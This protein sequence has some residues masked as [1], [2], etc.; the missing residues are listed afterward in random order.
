MTPAQSFPS[1]PIFCTAGNKVSIDSTTLS[2]GYQPQ[3]QLPC[4]YY[5]QL[6]NTETTML[7]TL[8]SGL[9]NITAELDLVVASGGGTPSL[10]QTN[11]V[12]A[13]LNVLYQAQAAAGWSTALGNILGSNWSTALNRP[14]PNSFNVFQGQKVTLTN[15]SGYYTVPSGVY[16]LRVTCVGGG[17]GGTSGTAGVA[18]GNGGPTTFG[19]IVASGSYGAPVGNA[20]GG[21]GAP[22]GAGQ[23][24]S[25][26]CGGGTIISLVNASIIS[27][28]P[29]ALIT[30]SV[31]VGGTGGAQGGSQGTYGGTGGGAGAVPFAGTPLTPGYGGGGAY[32]LSTYSGGTGGSGIIII[33]Y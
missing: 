27:T 18:G 11:Q 2:I 7:N 25:Q 17:G 31:G 5:N 8:V 14:L 29:G 24:G 19:A 22:G 16:Q 15:G 12:M 3:Q 30:Y 28:T 26:G 21:G 4:E 1:L 10:A 6:E 13:A 20:L 33:E 23:G 9:T 32:G